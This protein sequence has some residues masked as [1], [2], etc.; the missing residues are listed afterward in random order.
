[1]LNGV[2]TNLDHIITS[3]IF[4][5]EL[6]IMNPFGSKRRIFLSNNESIKAQNRNLGFSYIKSSNF[7]KCI[8]SGLSPCTIQISTPPE[9]W[10]A[11]SVLLRLFRS[12]KCSE[13]NVVKAQGARIS[14][15]WEGLFSCASWRDMSVV[16]RIAGSMHPLEKT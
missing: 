3:A 4:V 16:G 9:W 11:L 8:G 14:I 15:L 12:T 6:K 2:I 7:K 10:W 13:K 5:F 1:M